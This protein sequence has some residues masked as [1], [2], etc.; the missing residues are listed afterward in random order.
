MTIRRAPRPG[1]SLLEVLLAMAIFLIALIGIGELLNISSQQAFEISLVNKAGQLLEDRMSAVVSGS[2]PITGQSETSFDQDPEW[3]W[4]MDSQAD[5][6]PNL[7]RVTVKVRWQ[8]A[9]E[10]DTWT[11]SRYVI[12]PAQI[13][14]IESPS[15][16]S[17]S[18][19][20][21]S[22]GP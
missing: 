14:T 15:S 12:D 5:N 7:Y 19:S 22:G 4:S 20:S 21:T 3:V 2:V 8:G 9:G 11:L 6:T 16:S 1:F 10:S 13:G 17:S 18:T